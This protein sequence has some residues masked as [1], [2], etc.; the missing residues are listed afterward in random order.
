MRRGSALLTRL[1]AAALCLAG[2]LA[3]HEASAAETAAPGL[4]SPYLLDDRTQFV[5]V[6]YTVVLGVVSTA[7]KPPAEALAVYAH[8]A[9]CWLAQHPDVRQGR[10]PFTPPV[11]IRFYHLT[12]EQPAA[13][14]QLPTPPFFEA[15]VSTC[16]RTS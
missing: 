8:E 3:T 15:T 7:P 6:G 14:A 5:I 11:T 9:F 13:D 12:P 1:G 16:G 2:A 10:I 4:T